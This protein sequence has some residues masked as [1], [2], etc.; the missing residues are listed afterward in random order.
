VKK[1][2][3][4]MFILVLVS[5]AFAQET[6]PTPAPTR[7]APTGKKKVPTAQPSPSAQM[8]TSTPT[9]SPTPGSSNQMMPKT[10]SSFCIWLLCAAAVCV[11]VLI[12]AVIAFSSIYT[13]GANDQLAD[14]ES[15]KMYHETLRTLVAAAALGIPIIAATFK[16]KTVLHI[17]VL[18]LAAFLLVLA[19]IAAIATLIEMSR[20]Y[21]KARRGSRTP[22][23]EKA[24]LDQVV[25]SI[26][27]I[28]HKNDIPDT[29]TDIPDTTTKVKDALPHVLNYVKGELNPGKGIKDDALLELCIWAGAAVTFFAWGLICLVLFVIV[30]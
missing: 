13:S 10:S 1:F 28:L 25:E 20:H 30:S 22:E 19:V 16:D 15:R 11:V 6:K 3:G 23:D 18:R 9:P 5:A 26:V 14:E 21:E 7:A 24:A 8:E 27:T 29:T 17:W 4:F 12:L 2:L